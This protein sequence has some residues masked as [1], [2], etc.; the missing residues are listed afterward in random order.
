MKKITDL[1]VVITSFV[2][3]ISDV[4][5]NLIIAAITGSTVM[6]TQA[7][8]GLSD[9][10]TGGILYLGVK[11]SKRRRN[12]HYQFGHGREI[13]FWVLMAGIVMF[14][15][16]GGASVYFGYQQFADPSP[17]DNIWLA[18]A[19][20]TFGF[21]TNGYAF[22]LSLRRLSN[23]DKTRHWFRQLMH[24]SIVET[25]ATFLIDFLGT[26]ST[27]L[28]FLALGMYALTGNAMFDGIGA[29]MIGLSMMGVALILINDVRSLIVGKAVEPHLVERIVESAESVRGIESVLDIHSMYLG[30]DRLLVIIEV[31]VADGLHTDQVE[32]L[33]DRVKDTVKAEVPQAHHIQVEPETPEK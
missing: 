29:M 32:R 18:F 14:V 20:L 9:L 10:V 8:Q 1:R 23:H 19:M 24:S 22:S 12:Q 7:L 30:S 15:G 17:L 2:V 27:L 11:R 25:K 3:S 26:A 16:T 33:M 21:L 5:L 31:H 28:G 13:F 6:L 4:A